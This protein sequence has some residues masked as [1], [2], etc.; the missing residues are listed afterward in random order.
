MPDSEAKRRWIKENST[1]ITMKCMKKGDA[2]IL[3]YLEG[4]QKS[5][6][7]KKAMRILM[8]QEGFVYTPEEHDA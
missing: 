8:E 4:K 2:D 7:L 1:L 5:T 3:Q 6:V